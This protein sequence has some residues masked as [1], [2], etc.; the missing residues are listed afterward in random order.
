MVPP[1][2]RIPTPPLPALPTSR[3]IAA[4]GSIIRGKPL[5]T[6][7]IFQVTGLRSTTEVL[8][9]AV[10]VRPRLATGVSVRTSEKKAASDVL[11]LPELWDGGSYVEVK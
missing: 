7:Y 11:S 9:K 1:Y 8:P 10:E 6:L 5:E 2:L 4:A 3:Q